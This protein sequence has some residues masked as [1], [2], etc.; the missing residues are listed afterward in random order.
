M[1]S[2]FGEPWPSGICDE[3]ERVATPVGVPCQF[4]GELIA[5]DDQG[6]FVWGVRL[7]QS[8]AVEATQEPAHR[9]CSYREVKGGIGHWEDH[10]Y[11]CGEKGDPDGGRTRRQ[12]ALEVW[13]LPL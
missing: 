3:G 8:L 9:E 6:S 2:Y 1:S 10:A 13:A 12:S 7:P 5:P 4:C 11:W